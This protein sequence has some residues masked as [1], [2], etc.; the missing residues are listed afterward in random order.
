M[1]GTEMD[2]PW[3]LAPTTLFF[4]CHQLCT[5]PSCPTPTKTGDRSQHPP[6]PRVAGADTHSCCLSRVSVKPHL[7]KGRDRLWCST[8]KLRHSH[9][10]VGSKAGC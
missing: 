4:E 2:C 6:S 8:A 7:G 9:G 5:A 3:T 1:C 10:S